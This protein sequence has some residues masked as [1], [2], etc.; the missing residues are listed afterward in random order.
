MTEAPTATRELPDGV[1]PGE[2]VTVTVRVPVDGE[3]NSLA[4]DEESPLAVVD[5]ETTP[6]AEYR[7]DERQWLFVSVT[8]RTAVVNY[9]VQ[10]PDDAD[11]A[12]R[13][14][15]DGEVSGADMSVGAVGDDTTLVVRRCPA[16]AVAGD[17]NRIHL[18]G[19]QRA[20]GNW[21]DD[22]P[23][24]GEVLDLQTVQRLIGLWVD[25]E[26]ATCAG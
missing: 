9:T 12:T 22:E 21:A 14:T 7:S 20:V 11:P 8:D 13:Y 1:Q 15:F 17:D 3:V 16:S 4:V 10:V 19:I 23:F 18:R 5:Q 25:S 6:Q 24:A 2:R 26:R